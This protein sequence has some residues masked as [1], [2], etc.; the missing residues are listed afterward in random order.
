M[1]ANFQS[2]ELVNELVNLSNRAIG[3][4][5]VESAFLTQTMAKLNEAVR[6]EEIIK[7]VYSDPT[8]YK[9]I[10]RYLQDIEL[11]AWSLKDGKDADLR[12]YRKLINILE[13]GQLPHEEMLRLLEKSKA[14]RTETLEV[15]EN[16]KQLY[17]EAVGWVPFLS[18][19]GEV[20][21]FS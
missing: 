16:Y 19:S 1:S 11:V 12:D 5:Q 6:D 21:P 2:Q 20:K 15:M 13:V 4:L 9:N 8:H 17:E 3:E 7:N 18:L 14:T 10:K